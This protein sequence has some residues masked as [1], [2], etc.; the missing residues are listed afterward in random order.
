LE[1]YSIDEFFG[2]LDGFIKESETERYLRNMQADLYKELSLPA[3]IGAGANKSIA[4][5]AAKSAK[6]FGVLVVKNRD[7]KNF[8]NDKPIRAL[9][10][11]GRKIGSYLERYGIKTLG[12]ILGSPSLL[13][14]LGKNGRD[15]LRELN[16]E[17][18]RFEADPRE[19]KQIGISRVFDPIVDRD[20]AL[21][22]VL[23]LCGHLAYNIARAKKEPRGFSFTIGYKVFPSEHIKIKTD[24][25]FSEKLL[26]D[27]AK[28]A[29]R[30]IDKNP[31]DAINYF[32][33]CACDFA[34]RFAAGELLHW[35]KDG[36]NRAVGDALYKARTKY[37]YG[38]LTYA[39]ST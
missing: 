22:R 30:E 16:G 8:V 19:R 1:Q 21:R 37:G 35:Q 36:K 5:L 24:R 3:S 10:G 7:T 25:L 6:P 28:D 18:I 32:A 33:I 13:T 38:I 11:I 9:A 31:L 34:G 2:S 17:P 15:L 14:A 4:K 29:F 26:R 27:I 39:K 20:E 23:I 12:D